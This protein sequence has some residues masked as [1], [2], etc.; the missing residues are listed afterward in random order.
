MQAQV[1]GACWAQ[2]RAYEP[3][4]TK[5]GEMLFTYTEPSP[6]AGTLQVLL[7]EAARPYSGLKEKEQVL[8]ETVITAEKNPKKQQ[9]KSETT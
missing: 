6:S 2:G 1:T 4:Q 8:V 3:M 9:K 7:Q 5:M